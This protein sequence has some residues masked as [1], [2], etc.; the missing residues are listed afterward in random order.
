MCGSHSR[1]V[2]STLRSA[3]EATIRSLEMKDSSKNLVFWR[4]SRRLLSYKSGLMI[5]WRSPGSI[6]I[7]VILRHVQWGD[8]G[9]GWNSEEMQLACRTWYLLTTDMKQ[10]Q[11]T[12]ISFQIIYHP[13]TDHDGETSV[14]V[15]LTDK[16]ESDNVQQ[17]YGKMVKKLVWKKEVEAKFS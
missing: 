4:F 13:S 3:T 2:W 11:Y 1:Q 16:F 12:W 9:K 14:K 15:K 17:N 8:R 6:R 7:T 5:F 10:V